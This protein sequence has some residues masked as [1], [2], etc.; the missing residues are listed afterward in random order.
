MFSTEVKNQSEEVG[1]WWQ[2]DRGSFNISFSTLAC[3][4]D[5]IEN[6]N[7]DVSLGSLIGASSPVCVC[8]LLC[9]FFLRSTS[10]STFLFS[11][12]VSLIELPSCFSGRFRAFDCSRRLCLINLGH[13]P[14][15]FTRL[16]P[17]ERSE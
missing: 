2:L 6:R 9:K 16:R 13:E 12:M 7:V 11:A 3:M 5:K 1:T 4:S 14:F 10:C 15:V 17:Q 8:L